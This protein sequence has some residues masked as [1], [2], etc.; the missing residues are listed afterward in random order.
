MA[1]PIALGSSTAV[2]GIRTPAVKPFNVSGMLV[3]SLSSNEFEAKTDELSLEE[4]LFDQR[5]T[6]K[7]QLSRIAMHLDERWRQLLFGRIDALYN[8][9]DWEEDSTEI[10]PQAFRTLLRFIVFAA[11]QKFPGLSVA[12]NG[13][14]VGTWVAGSVRAYV[15]FLRRD[16]ATAVF[17][18]PT[19]RG[20]EAVAWRGPVT[21]LR[22]FVLG[23]GCGQCFG[24]GNDGKAT[25]PP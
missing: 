18:K 20:D 22:S 16:L 13:N 12:P 2:A 9:Q 14:P 6:L 21:N 7:I 25:A 11:P 10:E 19:D 17:K 4:R 5:M 24:W 1:E 8:L 3:P 23:F 15:E